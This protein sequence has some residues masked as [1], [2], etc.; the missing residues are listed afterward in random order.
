MSTNQTNAKK[1]VFRRMKV[2]LRAA[3]CW[4]PNYIKSKGRSY[5]SSD[6]FWKY[7]QKFA[8]LFT[9]IFFR[10]TWSW[11]D[12]SST[13]IVSLG[14]A[15]YQSVFL[16]LEFRQNSDLVSF[17]AKHKFKK[18]RQK[19]TFNFHLN[20]TPPISRGNEIFWFPS[21]IF[22]RTLYF[23]NRSFRKRPDFGQYKSKRLENLF[24]QSLGKSAF[25]Y[26]ANPKSILTANCS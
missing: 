19:F 15:M 1:H 25:L 22:S 9:P 17:V 12:C 8:V 3:V 26:P 20:F 13:D 4:F 6:L 7:S 16:S 5:C 10:P 11:N 18:I 21:L 2:K 14:E 23:L 24:W